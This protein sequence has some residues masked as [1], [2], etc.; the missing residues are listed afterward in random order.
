MN[1]LRK[2]ELSQYQENFKDWILETEI[3]QN[4]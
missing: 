2:I 4:N 1:E 3:K